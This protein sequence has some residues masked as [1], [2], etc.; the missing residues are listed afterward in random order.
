MDSDAKR[1]AK[2]ARAR[3][4]ARARYQSDPEYR[5]H[6]LAL[7]RA[8]RVREPHADRNATLKRRYGL[9]LDERNGLLAKQRGRCAA[10]N[11]PHPG[12]TKAGKLRSWNVDH[13]H[14]TG[15]VRG[16]LCSSCNLILGHAKDDPAV[17]LACIEYLKEHAEEKQA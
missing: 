7:N 4:R 3:D 16:L 1:R 17:L 5:A 8:R 11:G 2:Y 12:R 6:R 10:C 13:D 15:K 9:T 14:E